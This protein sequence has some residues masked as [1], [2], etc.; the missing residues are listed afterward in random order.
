MQCRA[1]PTSSLARQL[2]HAVVCR[3]QVAGLFDTFFEY[4]QPVLGSVSAPTRV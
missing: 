1:A 2:P 4:L 3:W